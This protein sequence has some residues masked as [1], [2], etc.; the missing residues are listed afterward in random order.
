MYTELRDILNDFE[1]HLTS[2]EPNPELLNE[3]NLELDN[4]YLILK[5]HNVST[6]ED[7]IVIKNSL[8]T[9]FFDSNSLSKKI[10]EIK[11]LIDLKKES[12]LIFSKKIHSN[13]IK[14]I[15][16]IE[17]EINQLELVKEQSTWL[18]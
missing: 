9:V 17:K 14:A 13:R 16:K 7:L 12:L 4:L 1:S 10:N 8:A 2:L 11:K 3:K 15:P 18:L 6:I 5:K